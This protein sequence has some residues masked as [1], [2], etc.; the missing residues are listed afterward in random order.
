MSLT[1]DVV[2]VGAG[3]AGSTVARLL[4]QRSFRVLLLEE[5]PQVGQPCHCSGLVTPRTLEAAQ[6]PAGFVQGEVRGVVAY[7]PKG[8]VL[9]LEAPHTKALVIDRV[10]LDQA[11][12]QQA[13]EAG[14]ELLL[15]ARAL[16][17][18]GNG[19]GTLRLRLRRDGKEGE[20]TCRLV[21]GADGSRSVVARYI[22]VS[23][24]EEVIY[25]LG[26]EAA[27][28]GLDPSFVHVDLDPYT[29]PGWF[30]WAIPTGNGVVRIG[31]GT[32]Q[33]GISPRLLLQHLLESLPPLR[34]AKVLRLQG[35]VIP[36]ASW[37][38]RPLVGNGLMLVGDA[39]GQA[40]P[41][42]GG[43]I[44][45][46]IMAA[47]WCAAV[48]TRA[49]ERGDCS[50]RALA[51]YQQWWHTPLGRE[52]RLAAAL[53][54]LFL[55]L[56]PNELATALRLLGHPDLSPVIR[57]HGDI[58]FPGRAFMHLLRPRFLWAAFRFLPLSLWPKG[59]RVA[60]RWAYYQVQMG[61][62]PPL[63]P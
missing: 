20:V 57:E 32:S 24:P 5:H 53:R 23:A 27:I 61:L 19:G 18:E 7:G 51:P 48:A 33:R 26:G 58:D 38:P 10:G 47:R 39:G 31:V 9:P 14:A 36:L 22:P 44:F 46:G 40:K 54:L 45:T 37:R 1:Y 4:A 49:L 16:G 52:V 13:Q 6:V 56:T 35:G 42:S 29:F 55:G 62:P 60:V 28:E 12:A 15:G 43:G 21:I 8:V 50:T 11:L 3:P 2:V 25:A 30:G 34:G 63:L 59:V 41:S 17:I